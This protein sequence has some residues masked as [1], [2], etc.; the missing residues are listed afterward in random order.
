M[1]PDQLHQEIFEAFIP[2]HSVDH[3]HL[4]A[5]QCIE[6]MLKFAIHVLGWLSLVHNSCIKK[7]LWRVLVLCFKIRLFPL[8]FQLLK[9]FSGLTGGECKCEEMTL[10]SS[11][12]KIEEIAEHDKKEAEEKI[13]EHN[14]KRVKEE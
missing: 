6:R 3:P 13:A 5:S 14:K 7:C 4:L 10:L 11:V 12:L 8:Y 2:W 1:G 9:V